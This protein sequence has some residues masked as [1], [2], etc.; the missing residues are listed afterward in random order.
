MARPSSRRSTDG[1]RTLTPLIVSSARKLKRVLADEQNE[2]LDGLRRGTAVLPAR[3]QHTAKFAEAID[4]E[5]VARGRRRC[6]FGRHRPGAKLNKS[7]TASAI[8]AGHE[9]LAEWLVNPLRERLERCIADGDGDNDGITRRVRSVYRE[10]KTQHIDEQLDD[11]LRTTHGRGV[12]A[13]VPDGAPMCWGVD[14]EHPRVPMVT[15]THWPDA[16]R[17]ARRSRPVICSRH[18]TLA[19]A[20]CSFLLTVIFAPMRRSSDLHGDRP[21]RRVTG[22]GILIGLGALFLFVL[23]FGRA[24]A[25][26]Y[27]D[28]LWHEALG[29]GDVFWGVIGA[30]ATLFVGFFPLFIVISAFNLF[31]ADRMAPTSFPANVHPYVERFHDLFGHRLRLVRYA[32]RCA[33]RPAARAADGRSVAE[34]L[35]FRHSR[36][37]GIADEQFGVDVGFYVFRL[38][39]LTFVLNWLFVALIVVLLLTAAAHILNGGVVFVSPMPVVRQ[40]T[41]AHIAVLLAVLAVVKAADYWLDPVRGH[42]QP[43]RHRAGRDLLRRQG[44]APGDP[45]A[46]PDRAA[47]GRAVPVGGQDRVVPPAADRVRPVAR[48]RHRGRRDLPGRGPVARG[49]PEPGER[50]SSRSSNATSTPPGRR[51]GS[52]DVAGP[53][54]R[55]RHRLTTD[56]VESDL[57]PAGERPPA[58]PDRD[59][60][61]LPSSTGVRWR[62]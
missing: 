36:E 45:A 8:G 41:K 9:A 25:R 12:F 59:G 2:V 50:A 34:W 56:D 20:A 24:I 15:T 62:V 3:D 35:L 58:E 7:Q 26:F 49:Q 42:Q 6:G 44:A 18:R 14:A 19:A 27:V 21:R 23:V 17:R 53:H 5:L 30:K 31:I 22:R 48:R 47:D 29:R 61:T 16:W 57:A 13:A 52:T 39:F 1:T 11:V 37:F 28:Y 10:W 38:P 43:A 4:D 60:D 51:S 54:G 33:L 55:V 46:D 32:S 40:S